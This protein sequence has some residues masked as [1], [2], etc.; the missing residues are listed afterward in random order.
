M[1]NISFV[2]DAVAIQYKM[3]KKDIEKL[4]AMDQLD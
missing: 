4:A 3:N 2:F 1:E